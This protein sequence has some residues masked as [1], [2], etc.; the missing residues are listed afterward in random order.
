MKFRKIRAYGTAAIGV[1][2]ATAISGPTA[3][4]QE[5]EAID[6]IVVTGSRI[7]RSDIDANSPISVIT[8]E[9][10]R[11]F[12][13]SN[14]E[15]FLRDMPQFVAAVGANSNNG[16][17]GAATIDLRDMGEERTLVLIDGKRFVPF[18]SQ[19][20][21]DLS[22]IPTSLIERVEIITGG[23][24]AVYGADAIAG[25]VNFIM[26]KNFEG[27]E[28][29]SSYSVSGESDA[30]RYDFSFTVGGNFADDRGNIVLNAGY[31]KQDAVTQ[32][33][34][35]FG[36]ESLDDLL[37]PVG[38]F[39]TPQGTGIDSGFPG[40]PPAFDGLTQ[41]DPNGDV[42]PF[43]NTFN[44]NPFNLFLVPQKKWTATAIGTYDLTDNVEVFSRLSFA[45]NRVD[46]IIAPTGTFFEQFNLAVDN[47]FFGPA[48]V[49]RFTQVDANESNAATRGDGRVDLL[50]GRRLVE[51]G[52]RDSIYEN[53][54]FQVVGGLKGD[55]G[56]QRWEVFGQFGRTS[57]NQ[58]FKNDIALATTQQAL[59]VVIDP[60]SG[61]IV[62][63][64][65]SGGC[66]PANLFGAGNLS[67]AGADFL[68]LDLNE[69]NKTNQTIFGA[70]ISGDIPIS[71]PWANPIAYAAG[72]EYR[73][74]D[75]E[76][77]PDG[78][79][80]SGN[81]IGFGA[82]SP[83]DAEI[84]IKEV[85]LETLIPI[86]TDVPGAQTLA[87]EA[88]IRIA[89]YEN[90]ATFS[91]GTVGSDF[92]NT[93][94]K[95]GLTWTPVEGYRVRAMFQRAVRAPTLNEIGQ[96]RTP[97]TGDL[98]NDPC[99]GSNPVGDAALTQLCI[100]TG[101]PAAAIGSVVSIIAGQINNFVGGNPTL[102]PEEADTLTVGLVLTPK[103]LPNLVATLDW[104]SIEIDDVVSQISEQNIVDAC[105]FVEQD[106][107]GTF[108]SLIS[109]NQINGGLTGP[110]AFGV[111]VSKIN[112]A[113]L[114]FE[115]IDFSLKY[116]WDIG[117]GTL[118][119]GL[120]GTY[121][122]TK[123]RQDASFLP[124]DECKGL[125]GNTCF[126][127]GAEMRWVQTTNWLMGPWA[128]Q[129][130]W[131]FI[132]SL[133]QDA[134]VLDGQPASDFALPEIPSFSYFDL[135][136]KYELGE[137]WTVRAGVNN[138]LDKQP[139]VTGNDF[140]GTLQNSGNTFP[141]TYDPIGRS[142]FVGVNTRF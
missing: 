89:D 60:V 40:D 120:N 73:R 127:P 101:V 102:R 119:L 17:N 132:D 63:A 104:Y 38:S 116:A 124:I 125:I 16:N 100:D 50:L 84:E 23:A 34:R 103:Q 72:V 81:A 67:Q 4:A 43:A 49:A 134:I 46:T 91:T 3:L 2:I 78:N 140:G 30:D 112:A 35:P 9:Q 142:F 13:S 68:R 107:N 109:R 24:S 32:N 45:N 14:V 71:L 12:N 98:G 47:P 87:L 11:M 79:F 44:F 18:D 86:L 53:T 36:V 136:A 10:I 61:E 1:L 94:W 111:D 80:A 90:T 15:E 115:G 28:F 27:F 123:E 97:S 137:H 82:S 64:D 75:G 129:L 130:R 139:P 20:F 26:K 8:A 92:N 105:Y 113:F 114:K 122:L 88:G 39:T 59:D 57:R 41:F 65:P 21:V 131:Q 117:D 70:S 93:S 141:A 77:L 66:V 118:D 133:K 108:C 55:W 106:A 5:Q 22:M 135:A 25:V 51:I 128:V 37:N 74:E 7:S 69:V 95:A 6:E 121:V 110:K 62:C 126:D 58:V 138:L 52:T 31:T 85:F 54:A 33:A 99:E 76:H 96:P 48:S 19:G 83:V 29:D 56:D 42:I